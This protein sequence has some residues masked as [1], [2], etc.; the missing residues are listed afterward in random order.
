MEHVELKTNAGRLRGALERGVASFKGVRYAAPPL[1][2]RRFRPP[3]PVEPW[4]GVRDALALGPSCPQPSARPEG[5]PG[6]VLEDEDCLFLNVWTPAVGDAKRR[7]VMVWL[8]GGGFAIGS[9]SWPL[10]DGASL[11]RRGDVVVV[12][13]NHR[14]G[15]LG[16]LHLAG[17]GGKGF[18]SSGNVGMLDLVAALEW[19]R[20]EIATLGGDPSNVTIFGESGGGAKVSTLLAMPSAHGLFHKAVIQSGPGLRVLSPERAET[21]AGAALEALGIGSG[22]LGKLWELPARTL[23]E[24]QQ[25]TGA[26]GLRVGFSPVR[27]GLAIPNHPGRMLAAGTAADVALLVG[28]T[29]DEATLFLLA[30]KALREPAAFDDA[31]LHS[32]L[33]VWGGSGEKLAAAYRASR[34]KASN[35][36]ILLAATTDAM[37][38]IPSIRLVEQHLSKARSP[39]WMYLFCWSAGPL[40]AG[41]GFELPFVFDNIHEPVL[42]PSPNRL[43]LAER[44][45]EAWIAFARSGDPNHDGLPN[46]P[47]YRPEQRATMI[48]DRGE[49]AIVDDPWGAEREAWEG[50]QA[51]GVGR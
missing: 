45:S 14:L 32:R 23:V 44:M 47:S 46:W 15:I 10:Y 16:Y 22:Q 12:T 6:E 38:R 33:S 42:R 25:S 11:A 7:P 39:A 48:F 40:R 19:V 9:G 36:D 18:E 13:V 17:R 20:D 37:M 51:P 29:F 41:H 28:T 3:A 43:Q 2:Q 27:D 4:Q 49:C 1:G 21:N 35:G 26:A 30:D 34:P 24:A 31:A 8:H 50:V 5:W